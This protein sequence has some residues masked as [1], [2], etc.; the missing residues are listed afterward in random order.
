MSHDNRVYL[1]TTQNNIVV[2]DS[3][4]NQITVSHPVTQVIEIT[5]AT[6]P[7]IT[8]IEETPNNV[9]VTEAL[10]NTVIVTSPGPQGPVVTESDPVFTAWTS[11]FNS[12]TGSVQTQVNSLNSAT[13]SYVLNSVTSSMSV[14]VKCHCICPAL[15]P[16]L[17]LWCVLTVGVVAIVKALTKQIVGFCPLHFD[18]HA[19]NIV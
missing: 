8:V 19:A 13:S 2:L 16:V 3:E 18:F 7:T 5:Q 10:G 17:K 4:H 6:T 12:Y 14:L 9:S 15:F 1:N 11:S